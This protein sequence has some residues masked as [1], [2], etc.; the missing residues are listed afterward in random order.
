MGSHEEFNHPYP[1]WKNEKYFV[2]LPFKLNEDINPTKTT[3]ARMTPS[4][5]QAVNAMIC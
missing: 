4:D 5:I 2:D 1:L 3:H